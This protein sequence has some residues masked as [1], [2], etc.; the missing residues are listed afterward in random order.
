[1][2]GEDHY[3]ATL[4][5][6]GRDVAGEITVNNSARPRLEQQGHL[7]DLADDVD[8]TIGRLGYVSL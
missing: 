3:R 4:D 7:H 6:F 2:Y 8:A 1:V 5:H